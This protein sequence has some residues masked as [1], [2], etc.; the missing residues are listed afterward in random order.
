VY[1]ARIDDEKADGMRLVSGCLG[2]SGCV[3]HH[4]AHDAVAHDMPHD[5]LD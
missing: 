4:M 5:L 2:V 3:E 1:G